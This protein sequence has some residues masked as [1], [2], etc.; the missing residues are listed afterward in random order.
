MTSAGPPVAALPVG[1]RLRRDWPYLVLAG[2]VTALVLAFLWYAGSTLLLLGAAILVA[3]LLDAAAEGVARLT[4][5]SR[6]WGLAAVCLALV[7]VML[8]AGFSVVPDLASQAQALVAEVRSTWDAISRRIDDFAWGRQAL[9]QLQQNQAGGEGGGGAAGVRQVAQQALSAA[10]ATVSGLTNLLIIVIVGLYLAV[11][12][13]LYLNGSLRLVPLRHRP[14]T[15]EILL[16][17]AK[18]LRSWLLGQ[19]LAMAVIGAASWLGLWL[20]GIPYA[21]ILGLVA[22]LFAFVPNIGPILGL[23]PALLVA[24]GVSP[25]H[26][27]Y[28]LG[29]YAVIQTVESYLLTPMIQRRAVDLPPAL[30]IVVQVAMGLAAGVL[31]LLLA[32]PLAAAA[33]VVVRMA[34]VEDVLGDR[35]TE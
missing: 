12:P 32:T 22:A 25:W 23:I 10:S 28:V 4:G 8:A 2:L 9:E 15:R 18:A 13:R 24:A 34:Y 1:E 29:L 19:L 27:L 7:G 11:E 3:F 30:L 21:A 35:S 17:V 6:R 14:R 33:M 26:P 20:L 16:A 31:G 5:L